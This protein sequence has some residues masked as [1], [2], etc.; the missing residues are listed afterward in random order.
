MALNDLS[1][2]EMAR[3]SEQ[4]LNPHAL[5]DQI[6]G[7]K[8]TAVWIDDLQRVHTDI[9]DAQAPQ[10]VPELAAIRVEQAKVDTVHDRRMRG[11]F[12]VLE[13]LE[14]IA[15]DL[16]FD[17][18]TIAKARA[19][20]FPDGLR[21]TRRSYVEE[22]AEVNFVEKRLSA[23]TKAL[24]TQLTLQGQPFRAY[25]DLWLDAARELGELDDKR[26]AIEKKLSLDKSKALTQREARNNWISVV[27]MIR[28]AIEADTA[29]DLELRDTLLHR[30]RRYEAR[31]GKDV[32]DG[33]D[34]D[35]GTSGTPQP[36]PAAASAAPAAGTGSDD[37]EPSGT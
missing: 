16:G 24:L 25:V 31:A 11:A 21:M 6:L 10:D 18:A 28:A 34:E 26:E 14:A 20:L 36:D 33:E 2:L 9:S 30:L 17:P 27:G 32:P 29:S 3:V 5:R 19:E 23:A 4:W 35:E 7:L 8:R 22:A 12:T 37:D 15:A 13:G 1:S